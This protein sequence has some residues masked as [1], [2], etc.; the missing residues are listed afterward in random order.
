MIDITMI[1]NA[2]KRATQRNSADQATGT[3]MRIPTPKG[4]Q[5]SWGV[6]AGA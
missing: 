1:H 5:S 3:G 6:H 2:S 4:P